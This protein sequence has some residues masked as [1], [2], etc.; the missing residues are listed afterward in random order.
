MNN[1]K[2]IRCRC[3]NTKMFEINQWGY[4]EIEKKC[5]KCKRLN[6]ITQVKND[7]KV[8]IVIVSPFGYKSNFGPKL[9]KKNEN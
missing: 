4:V 9:I 3:C 1:K 7:I 2:D 6:R 5:V 8:E